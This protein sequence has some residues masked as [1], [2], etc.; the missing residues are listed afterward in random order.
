MLRFKSAYPKN[1]V[2]VRGWTAAYFA[3]DWHG[4]RE[5]DIGKLLGLTLKSQ[6]PECAIF[7]AKN[8]PGANIKRIQEIVLRYGTSDQM[9]DLAHVFG[10]HKSTL[11]KYAMLKEV[12]FE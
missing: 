12:F 5:V 8:V 6:D 9:K 2:W 10:A 4:R 11:E 7:F 3:A 1:Q